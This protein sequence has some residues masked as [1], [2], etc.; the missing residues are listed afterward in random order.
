VRLRIL[1]YADGL[2]GPPLAPRGGGESYP[3][4]ESDVTVAYV[5]VSL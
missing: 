2:P 5:D 3:A 1:E 4:S